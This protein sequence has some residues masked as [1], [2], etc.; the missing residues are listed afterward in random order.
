MIEFVRMPGSGVAAV[1][2]IMKHR[3]SKRND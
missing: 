2:G 1:V 3:A